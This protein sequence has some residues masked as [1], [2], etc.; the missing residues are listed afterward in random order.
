MFYFNWPKS[1]RVVFHVYL[2]IIMHKIFVHDNFFLNNRLFRNE[3]EY[4]IYIR[5]FEKEYLLLSNFI[6]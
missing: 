5:V 6:Y 4:R 1:V 2:N 3:L